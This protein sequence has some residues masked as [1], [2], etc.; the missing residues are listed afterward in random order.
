MQSQQ[1]LHT[2]CPPASAHQVLLRLE[3]PVL[4]E[5]SSRQKVSDSKEL[6][7]VPGTD[8]I[9]K[10]FP[11]SKSKPRRLGRV[12]VRQAKIQRRLSGKPCLLKESEWPS[13]L[14]RRGSDQSS[15]LERT[16]FYLLNLVSRF[17]AL[18]AVCLAGAGDGMQLSLSHIR[19]C[20]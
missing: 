7:E 6:Q 13:C 10:A 11:S 12:T 4:L 5:S 3:H 19:S 18:C 1:N 14:P 17:P 8:Q 16:L 15:H 9:H 20:Q 2:V